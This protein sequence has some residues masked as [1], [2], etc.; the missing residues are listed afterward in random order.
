MVLRRT[1]GWVAL[2]ILIVSLAGC[3]QVA[4]RT[5]LKAKEGMADLSSLAGKGYELTRLNG[6]WEFYGHQLLEPG[7]DWEAA[8]GELVRIPGSWNGYDSDH[9]L[10][11]GQGYGTYRLLFAAHPDQDILALR[12]PNIFTAYKLWIDGKLVQS[13]GVVG[14][15]RETTVP[16][17][18]PG[19]ATFVNDRPVHE[20]VIQ[21]ANFHHRKGGIWVDFVFGGSD[22]VI[23]YQ[24]MDTVNQMIIFG[25]L[26]MIGFYH[27][28]LYAMRR[29]E[30]FTLYFG[31]LCLMVGLR[32]IVTGN[33]YLVQWL[34]WVSWETGMKLEYTAFALAA[35]SSYMYIYH[36]FPQEASRRLLKLLTG[37]TLVLCAIVLTMPGI[38]FTRLLPV[39]QLLVIVVSLYI[40]YVL[41]LA[42]RRKR[43]GAVYVLIGISVF[44]LTILN[45]MAFY[46]EWSTVS[47][48][49]PVGLFFVIM[50]QSF[51]ISSRF[52]K[53]L[54]QIEQVSAEARQ[55]NASLEE[56][57]AERTEE[58]QASH[59]KLEKTHRELEKM[60]TSRTRLLSNISHDLR[61]PMTLIQ[62][63]LE[64]MQDG[65]VTEPEQ[66]DRYVR[67]M[68]GKVGGLNRLI[69][70]L[71]ELSKFEAGVVQFHKEQL[72]LAQWVEELV[73]QYQL[74]VESRG[75]VFEC[76]LLLEQPDHTADAERIVLLLD[77][78]RMEQVMSNLIYNA[79]GHMPEGGTLQLSFQYAAAQS[80]LIVSVQDTGAGISEAD[81]PHIFER[82]YRA[83]RHAGQ[84]QGSGIGLAIVKEIVDAHL[85]VI[86]VESV[87]GAGTRFFIELPAAEWPSL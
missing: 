57:I 29:Q 56:R 55:L 11:D 20:L 42:V 60:E 8:D 48:I 45:D 33:A 9:R 54:A 82:F 30:R 81:L 16:E 21:I 50:M 58:L 77:R 61:T 59:A 80:S 43:T 49:V 24:I 6:D 27:L 26:A 10:E 67:M 73:E 25:S 64:A 44:V 74:D 87:E 83:G 7:A 23:R 85:G 52:S 35:W 41:A 47:D 53:A 17:Q 32:M 14:M 18:Y 5:H 65:V 12:V 36:L 70:E 4:D 15:S 34:P 39:F 75:I 40:L 76:S 71:F 69:Q 72:T 68:L 3:V 22:D 84:A 62:G 86:G 51:I 31:I 66:R 46:N 38:H 28:G 78:F 79:L 1:A 63:Y 2:L 37:C 19:I 13:R